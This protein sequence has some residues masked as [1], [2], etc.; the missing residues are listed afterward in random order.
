[1]RPDAAPAVRRDHAETAWRRMR[2]QPMKVAGPCYPA[3]GDGDKPVEAALS[4]ATKAPATKAAATKA[5][6][7]TAS[8]TSD[9][10]GGSE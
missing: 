7:E 2:S 6:P 1:M 10:K 5:T 3:R 9:S 4:T 8:E